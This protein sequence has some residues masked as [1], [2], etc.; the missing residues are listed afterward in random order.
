MNL[1]IPQGV[2]NSSQD[3]HRS[4]SNSAIL[5]VSLGPYLSALE[6]QMAK[7]NVHPRLGALSELL[8]RKAMTK[9]DAF[10]KTGVDRKT[11]SKIDRGEEVKKETL[12]KVANKLGVPEEYFSLP[13]EATAADD[14][15]VPSALEPGTIMLRK[16]D[17]TRLQELLEG[18]ETLR[19][20]LKA[21]VRDDAARTFLEEFEQAVEN[22]RKHLD[23]NVPEVWDGD[24]SLR[25]QLNGLKTADDIA[26][27]LERFAD[28]GV[29]LL[30]A[31]YLFWDCD[32]EDRSY[33]D[34]YWTNV[35]YRSCRTVILSV[36]SGGTQS[37]RAPIFQGSLP[38]R[39]APNTPDI[40]TNVWINGVQLP[41][42]D[43]SDIPF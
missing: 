40:K 15:D 26:A 34:V 22:F 32:S 42:R 35:N 21:Q 1:E 25:F 28:H 4:S 39:F 19:W 30:G 11:L 18:G 20:H 37:R 2:Q 6:V 41:T 24:P 7:I 23:L 8:K 3:Q 38:P 16:L 36:E 27:R 33:E 10:Q 17:W 5:S 14:S 13:V 43:D 9:M 31:D 29:V 12:Q